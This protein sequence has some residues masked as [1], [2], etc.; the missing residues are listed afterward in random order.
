MPPFSQSISVAP[1]RLD[2]LEHARTVVVGHV[3]PGGVVDQ[4][5][6]VGVQLD[7]LRGGDRLALVDEPGDER[8]QRRVLADAPV[9]EAGE[10][11]DR[12]RRRVEDQLPPLRAARVGD[13]LRRHPGAGARVGEALDLGERRRARLERA[14][15]RVALHVPLHVARLEDAAGRERRAADHALD[16]LGDRLLVADAVLHRRDAAVANAWA[17][18]SIAAPVCMHFV[19]TIPKSQDGS[20]AASVV[21]RSAADDVACAGEPQPVRVDRV[22]VGPVEVVGPDLDVVEPREVRREQRPDGAAA[23]DRDPHE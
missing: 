14:E 6:R 12:V 19:A 2:V 16:V 5:L 9:R 3:G 23:D 13:R 15:R 8:A 11:A 1:P 22:D 10:R 17:V 7:P 4:R 20:S 18:A 21:A